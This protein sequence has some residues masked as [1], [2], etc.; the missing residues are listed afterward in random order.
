MTPASILANALVLGDVTMLRLRLEP[1]DKA[2]IYRVEIKLRGEDFTLSAS[3]DSE[4]ATSH[5][6]TRAC[7][8]LAELMA[9]LRGR[10]E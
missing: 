2:V 1:G 9:H 7:Q 4:V 3:A 6:V 5:A 10:D 8:N